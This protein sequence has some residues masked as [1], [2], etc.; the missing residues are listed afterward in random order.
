MKIEETK[1]YQSHGDGTFRRCD[2][3]SIGDNVIF[4]AN[5][6]VFHPETITLGTNVYIGHNTVLKGYHLNELAIGDQTWI[7]QGCFF[8]S[9]GGIFIGR[10]VGIGPMVKIITSVHRDDPLDIPVLHHELEFSRVTVEDGS[11]IGT[12]SI[13]LPGVKVGEG[14]IVGAGSVV[15]REVL[16]Y[17]VVGGIPARF[18]RRRSEGGRER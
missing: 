6:L 4:E 15:T 18:L 5:V 1:R 7:G 11:D 10:A 3:K 12:G 13:L 8:H 16:P 2:F 17:T 14:A 9:A